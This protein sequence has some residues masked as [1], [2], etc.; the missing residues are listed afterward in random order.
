LI[1]DFF[2]KGTVSFLNHFAGKSILVDSVALILA[3]ES[4]WA[5]LLVGLVWYYWFKNASNGHRTRALLVVGLLA[6]AVSGALSRTIQLV[7]PSH[8]RPFYDPSAHFHLPIGVNPSTEPFWRNSFPSD[9]SAIYFALAV[10][11]FQQSRTGGTV[12]YLVAFLSGF[13][14]VYLGYHWP[15]DILGG[16]VLGIACVLVSRIFVSNRVIT[17]VLNLEQRTPSVFY[18]IAF[19]ASY[20]VATLFS[21]IRSTGR[22]LLAATKTL[23][24]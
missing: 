15:S 12:A 6:T 20:F 10:I 11:C 13:A 21:D 14:R 3:V 1:F 5:V 17:W 8:P 18:S 24:P 9:H 7:V 16:A 23:A 2:D 22:I 19:V 4:Y